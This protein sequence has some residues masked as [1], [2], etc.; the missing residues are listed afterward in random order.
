[1]AAIN[2]TPEYIQQLLSLVH[3]RKLLRD[4]GY[5][6]NPLNDV[7]LAKKLRCARCT[8]RPKTVGK[9]EP[10]PKEAASMATTNK[11]ENTH[12]GNAINGPQGTGNAF[13]NS[14]SKKPRKPT[15]QW[16]PGV[17]SGNTWRC[18]RGYIYSPG[19]QSAN[20]HSMPTSI[21]PAIVERYQL[22]STPA[23][24]SNSPKALAVAIDCEMGTA[25]D[26]NP[27]LIRLT[28]IEYLTGTILID[29]LVSPTTP[30]AHFNTRYSGVSP[31]AMAAA[32]RAGTCLFGGLGAARAAV[33]QWVGAE[34]VLVGHD[35][36][37]DLAALRWAHEVV[38][39]SMVVEAEARRVRE[40]RKEEEEEGAEGE[41]G[42]AFSAAPES[43]FL[44]RA[45]GSKEKKGGGDSEGWG[46]KVEKPKGPGLSLKAVSKD[47]LG[48]DIQSGAH[49]SFEDALA[50]R[51]IVH[52]H[53][54]ANMAAF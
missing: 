23:H 9:P 11:K 7:E 24:R 32:Q 34:T 47:L 50:S 2:P 14:E 20:T 52:Y 48:R 53:V 8:K 43:E 19:C 26:G 39:D 45:D 21:T 37:H 13:K 12:P 10:F 3:S 29:T 27:E 51:D 31:A 5:S 36:K 22:T 41:D 17:V 30:M 49:D 33:W 28:L 42:E 4:K 54:M 15:C 44:M 6:L 40:M 35:V 18:C 1:M 46:E 38:V 16:H 25:T